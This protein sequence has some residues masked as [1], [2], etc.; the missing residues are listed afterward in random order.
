MYGNLAITNGAITDEITNIGYLTIHKENI[1]YDV[2]W[3]EG[4]GI[5][6]KF[7]GYY[8]H[9]RPIVG[10]FI[11]N[12]LEEQLGMLFN[13]SNLSKT[14][15]EISDIYKEIGNTKPTLV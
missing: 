11:Y 13:V 14:E 12:A 3:I 4:S 1:T 2:Y 5:H 10:V 15:M 7:E 8:Y 9:L 6:V